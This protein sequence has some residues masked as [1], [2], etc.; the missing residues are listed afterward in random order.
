MNFEDFFIV[1]LGFVMGIVFVFATALIL[2]FVVLVCLNIIKYNL[3][4][5][6][7]VAGLWVFFSGII[8]WLYV[9]D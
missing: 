2:G 5:G 6:V 3:L 7:I 4:L 8:A 9:N 1:C